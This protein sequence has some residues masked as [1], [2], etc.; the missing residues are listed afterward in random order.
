HPLDPGMTNVMPRG[1][2][3]RLGP[4]HSRFAAPVRLTLPYDANLIPDGMLSSD[5]ATFYYD[6]GARRWRQLTTASTAQDGAISSA[7]NH[8][9]DFISATIATPEHPG[10]ASFNPNTIRDIKVGD[11]SAG[12][13]VIQPPTANQTGAASLAFPI[14]I[15]SGRAGMQPHLSI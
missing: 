6:E 15:P 2:A 12:I 13:E 5:I 10:S 1:G 14:D 11:P 8:F 7:T 9:T 3:F 4:H